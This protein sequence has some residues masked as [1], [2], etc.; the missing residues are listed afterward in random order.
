MQG[1]ED[2]VRAYG[3]HELGTGLLLVSGETPVG[4][5]SRLAGDGLNAAL[6]VG[7]LRRDNPKRGIAGLALAVLTGLTILDLAHAE[8]AGKPQTQPVRPS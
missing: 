1:N 8:R 4:V 2:L 6:L 5:W 3:V 7:A